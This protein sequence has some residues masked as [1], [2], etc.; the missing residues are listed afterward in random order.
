MERFCSPRDQLSEQTA[1][2]C[3]AIARTFEDLC[4]HIDAIRATSSADST[5]LD[6]LRKDFEIIEAESMLGSSIVA[7]H[8]VI[9]GDDLDDADLQL[10]LKS[11]YDAGRT[12][13]IVHAT[14]DQANA[15]H[16]L[17]AGGRANCVADQAKKSRIALYGLQQ[18]L[19]QK[20]SYCLPGLGELDDESLREWHRKVV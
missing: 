2:E 14:Q 20:S 10:M 15:F 16:A 3:D 5:T 7:H 6:L 19:G 11:A 8:L 1:T 9:G 4:E 17:I 12:V 13:A 18:T